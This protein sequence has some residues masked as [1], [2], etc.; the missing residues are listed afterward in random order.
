M[1]LKFCS[2]SQENFQREIQTVFGKE[3]PIFGYL[4][5]D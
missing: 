5:P 4:F 2:L 1:K 3:F